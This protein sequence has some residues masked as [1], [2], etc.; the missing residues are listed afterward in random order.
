MK[1]LY[2][3]GLLPFA[4]VWIGVYVVGMSLLEN[5]GEP[6]AAA[7]GLVLSVFLAIWLKHN[8]LAER[9]GLCAGTIPAVWYIPLAVLTLGNLWCGAEM[10]YGAA[11][12]VFFLIK[13]LC[14]GF[15][16]EL[17]FRGF[18]FKA[19]CK[20]SIKWAVIV[21]SVTFGVGHIANLFN[22]SGMALA[23]NL[24]QIVSAVAIGFLYVVI[25]CRGGSL[26]PCMVSH[27]VFN[28]LSAFGRE[29]PPAVAEA[30]CRVA[31]CLIAVVYGIFLW[32]RLP[33]KE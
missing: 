15:L 32:K 31:I 29:N 28:C 9:F 13:M 10:R 17:I 22:G 14:V 2:D 16:E 12:T 27:G 4:L 5:F 18:L 25:F 26:L 7:G 30:V 1:R 24:A 11:E 21:S 8:G 33:E 6:A 3:K 23:E 19:L 20:D